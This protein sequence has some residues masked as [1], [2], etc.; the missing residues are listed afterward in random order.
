MFGKIFK[1]VI[2]IIISLVILG[3][4]WDLPL[5]GLAIKIVISAGL[6]AWIVHTVMNFKD[7]S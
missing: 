3:F 4:L 2:A 5:L 1:A 6:V 7:K